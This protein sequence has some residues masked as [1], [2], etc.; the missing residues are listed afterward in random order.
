MKQL[1][2]FLSLLLT[3][4]TSIEFISTNPDDNT[5]VVTSVE[6]SLFHEQEKLSLTL[7]E[8]NGGEIK[9]ISWKGKEILMEPISENFPEEHDDFKKQNAL[10]MDDS[11]GL[12]IIDVRK[13][14]A[15]SFRRSFNVSYNDDT[16]EY[17]VEVIYNVKNYSSDKELKYQWESFMK[18]KEKPEHY[19]ITGDWSSSNLKS[20][21]QS[22]L[23]LNGN[24][25]V[26][27][28][29]KDQL[30]LKI[31]ASKVKD[32]ILNLKNLGQETK[33]ATGKQQALNSKGR[34]SWKV[35]YIFKENL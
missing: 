28:P 34:I 5:T 21:A 14:R 26:K 4:C 25:I 11:S 7:S 31:V 12:L 22:D 19:L 16:D 33:I 17:T 6:K 35:Q 29:G 10:L 2:L 32:L 18:L 3:S 27:I 8:N 15:Y 23:P 1:L 9:S 13:S 20:I 24:L 30:T